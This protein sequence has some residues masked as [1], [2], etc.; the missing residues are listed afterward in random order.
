M[1]EI[2]GLDKRF[3]M[4]KILLKNWTSPNPVYVWRLDVTAE[5]KKIN[6]GFREKK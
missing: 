2:V 6:D 3:E 4:N 1:L 5:S